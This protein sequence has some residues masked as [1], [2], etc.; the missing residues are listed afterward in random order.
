MNLFQK[1]LIALTLLTLAGCGGVADIA[2]N[3]APRLVA[4]EIDD[5]FDLD[6]V[7]SDRLDS[8]LERFFA[9]HRNE[10]LARYQQFLDRA[11]LDAAD[12]ITAV[13]FLALRAEIGAAWDRALEKVIDNLGDLAVD[14]TPEQIES[15]VQYH[16]DKSEEYIEYLQKSEQ[17]REVERIQRAYERLESWYGEFDF[18]LED[19]VR[20]RLREI[21]DIF[22][23][24]IEFRERRQQALLAALRD[25]PANGFDRQRL[26]RILLDPT[27][28][29]ARTF[30]PAR[31]A[32]WQAYAAALE[33]ISSWLTKQQRQRVVI[34]LQKYA[35]VVER[36]RNDEQG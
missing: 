12:G 5:A 25:V 14:L 13:E 36:L 21:P 1:S 16:D 10:E 23:P 27:T 31:R 24:W 9:W 26:R 2:Y 6:T 4:S 28:G 35:R 3:S 34:K 11:A 15:F 29:H 8:R 30:E 19:R 32:Y 33:D 17:Q 18:L 22:P 20:A 7:Q